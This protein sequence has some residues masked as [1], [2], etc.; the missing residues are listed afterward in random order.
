[1]KTRSFLL[2]AILLVACSACGKEKETE[3]VVPVQVAP[4][5]R[6]SIRHIITADAIIYPRDQAGVVPKISAPVRR[7]LVNRGDRVKRGQLLAVLENRDLVAAALESRGQFGQAESNYR[8]TTAAAIPEEMTKAETDLNSARQALEAARKVLESRQ[9]LFK[10]GALA[11]KQ[12]DDAQ[13]AYAQA[14]GQFETAQLHVNA[15]RD[16]ARQEQINAAAA[17]VEAAKGHYQSAEAQVAYS[18]IRS[19]I[20]GVVTDRPLYAGEMASA[21][22]P[23]LTIMDVSDAIARV[24]LAQSLSKEVN[25][26]S[27]ATLTPSDGGA[28]LMGRVTIVS[29]AVDPSSTTVQVWV[30]AANPGGRLRPGASVHVAITAEMIDNALL[31]PASAVLPSDEG[32]VIVLVVDD[33]GVAHERKV[34]TGVRE[35]E[36]VQVLGG[37]Q[38]GERVITVGG[39]GLS[40]RAKVRVLKPGE[41]GG[42]EEDKEGDRR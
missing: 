39:L 25:V 42:G 28:P 30:Q 8:S 37:A 21:G 35:G 15:L 36:L 31:I 9:E 3:P 11:R 22:T 40:D 7:F 14:Q 27:E 33:Q 38:P 2:A 12:V 29:P 13:V 4:V 1:M 16:V 18:Q 20:D 6:G 10:A 23:L 26:G 32:G 34:E 24:S 5:I 19:P 41:K 17:Q